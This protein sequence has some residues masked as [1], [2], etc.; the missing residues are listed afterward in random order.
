MSET[1]GIVHIDLVHASNKNETYY[2]YLL[3]RDETSYFALVYLLNTADR[4]YMLEQLVVDS[5]FGSGKKIGCIQSDIRSV[6]CTR[7]VKLL[8]LKERACHRTSASHTPQQN[9]RIDMSHIILVTLRV[10]ASEIH[11]VALK[12]SCYPI[13]CRLV[14]R[15]LVCYCIELD[16]WYRIDTQTPCRHH[17]LREVGL[18]FVGWLVDWLVD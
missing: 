7:K 9:G 14:V 18:L 10:C 15:S 17:L 8:F 1:E 11:P 12:L 13:T 4:H 6:F 16:D 5:E 2:Y 3:R